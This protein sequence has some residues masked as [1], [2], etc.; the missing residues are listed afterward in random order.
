MTDSTPDS[1]LPK[2]PGFALTFLYYFSGTALVT[3][4]LAMK[5]L[6]VGLETGIPNQFGLLFGAIGGTLGAAVNRSA[7]LELPVKNRAAFVKQLEAALAEMGYSRDPEAGWEG[8]WIYRRPAI[9]QLFSGRIYVHVG[10]KTA[11]I[12]SRIL[13]IRGLKKRLQ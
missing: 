3:T 8:V 10:Q 12:S 1:P 4:V 5:T 6:G 2:G 11:V 7:T 9:R 13:H